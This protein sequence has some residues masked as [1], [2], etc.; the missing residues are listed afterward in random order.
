MPSQ[1]QEIAKKFL[2]SEVTVK[3]DRP[4]GSTHPEYNYTY[5]LNYGYLEGVNAPDGE[6]LDAYIIGPEEPLDS[7]TGKCVAIIHREDDDDDKLVVTNRDDLTET[8]IVLATEFQEK[9]FQSSVI[10]AES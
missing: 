6:E 9:W 2:G 3:V 1:S 7:F 5:P 10:M 4:F 8:E